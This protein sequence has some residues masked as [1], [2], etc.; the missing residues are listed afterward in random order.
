MKTMLYSE[1][2]NKYYNEEDK[3]L[4]LADEKK[5]DEK[6]AEAENKKKARAERAKEVEEAYKAAV[7]A[8]NHADELANKFISDYGSF[9]MTVKTPRKASY[10]LD[11]FIKALFDPST[12]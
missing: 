4:L 10:L 2:L 5:Y 11:D 8:R 12:F 9:H 1:K 6:I 3:A 7:D